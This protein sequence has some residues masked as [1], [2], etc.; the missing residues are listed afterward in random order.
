MDCQKKGIYSSMRSH[1][2]H[3]GSSKDCGNSQSSISLG[4]SKLSENIL[5]NCRV[6]R[7]VLRRCNEAVRG[8]WRY[9][10]PEIVSIL[11]T[12]PEA[13]RGIVYYFL[14]SDV[15]NKMCLLEE[16]L[17]LGIKTESQVLG[18]ITNPIVHLFFKKARSVQRQIHKWKGM[19]R[20]KEI[21]GGYLYA[22]FGSEFNI[23]LPIA[24]H[25]A[26]RFNTERLIIH[27]LTRNKAVYVEDCKIYP[28]ELT[29]SVPQGSEGEKFFQ[30]MW[31]L[32]FSTI[33]IEER[34]NIDLQNKCL[35]KKFQKWLCEFG[36][37]EKRVVLPEFIQSQLEL[38]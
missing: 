29:D 6:E 12:V 7:G 38:F 31:R 14:L 25:F 2:F 16:F 17:S 11:K 8:I 30:E 23:L 37:T 18:N 9:E 5:A 26:E 10:V 13:V 22:S 34:K 20:F 21:E 1:K 32:Y 3:C 15:D 19:L 33:G 36:M 4:L 24:R 28:M 27:D 35:P